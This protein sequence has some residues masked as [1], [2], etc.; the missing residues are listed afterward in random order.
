MTIRRSVP[1]PAPRLPVHSSHLFIADLA[2]LAAVE[3]LGHF[4]AA[5]I[6]LV[7]WFRR[8]LRRRGPANGEPGHL[9]YLAG[10]ADGGGSVL[11]A[12]AGFPK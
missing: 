5:P 12:E 2:A 8:K 9:L 7:Q 11:P 3:D 10:G 6:I 1:C 4:P